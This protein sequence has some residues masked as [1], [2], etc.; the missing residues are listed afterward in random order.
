MKYAND[1]MS[2]DPVV[3]DPD[4]P[5]RDLARLLLE[6]KIDGVCVVSD[7]KVQGVVTVM[8]LIFQERKVQ[9]P[10]I[11]S[12]VDDVLHGNPQR[13]EEDLD[14]VTGSKVSDIMT[15][16]A[17]TVQ[18]D[19]PLD[20]VASLMVDNHVTIVPV[21]KGDSFVGLITKPDILRAILKADGN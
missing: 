2:P 8:D 11:F 10:N 12:F 21:C 14:K 1:I 3:V 16:G 13:T 4:L 7:G 15:K 19:S 20:E 17:K 6:R 18:F 9:L 5:V